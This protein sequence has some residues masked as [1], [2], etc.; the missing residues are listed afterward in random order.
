MSSICLLY[1]DYDKLGPLNF[2]TCWKMS[3]IIMKNVTNNILGFF[4]LNTENYIQ[5]VCFG[6]NSI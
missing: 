3:P 6:D 1:F 4:V 2:L 5:L